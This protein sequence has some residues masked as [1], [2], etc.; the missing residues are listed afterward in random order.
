MGLFSELEKLGLANF[1][2]AKVFANEENAKTTQKKE[3]KQKK[4]EMTERDY[5][6]LREFNCPI[7]EWKFKAL[8]V[9]SGKARQ[10]ERGIDMRVF[11]EGIDPVKYDVISCPYCG[12]SA[13]TSQFDKIIKAQKE[14]IV[15]Q[16]SVNYMPDQEWEKLDEPYSYK[17][18][19]TRFK[20]ALICAVVKRA[21]AS[22]R[23]FISLKLHWLLESYMEEIDKNSEEYA[24]CSKDNEEC[25]RNAYEGFKKAFSSENLPVYGLDDATMPYMI[26]VL[27]YQLGDYEEAKHTI[28]RVITSRTANE[29]I[30]NLARD[31]KDMIDEKIDDQSTV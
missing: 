8:T 13:I 31:L 29:R 3:K 10:I 4:E 18:A 2:D 1:K 16:V 30:K 25:M 28:G 15:Q 26:S 7:C 17:K 27:A 21:K 6:I 12:Y 23:A 20:M 11:Y 19:I 9:K 5:L 24:K 14:F 22:E